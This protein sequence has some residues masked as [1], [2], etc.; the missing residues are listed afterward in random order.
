MYS[1][2]LPDL[3]YC[4]NNMYLDEYINAYEFI[5]IYDTNC[6][7]TKRRCNEDNKDTI[8]YTNSMLTRGS[9][10]YFLA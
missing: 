2:V 3:Y 10:K 9:F 1:T 7:I 8:K 4:D 6:V 5:L